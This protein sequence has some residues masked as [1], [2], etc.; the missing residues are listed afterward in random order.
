MDRASGNR[1][2]SLPLAEVCGEA[3]RLSERHG[4]LLSGV[5]ST[6]FHALCAGDE[7]ADDLV[8]ALPEKERLELRTW[9]QP[10]T[11]QP[12]PFADHELW[13]DSAKHEVELHLDRD[14]QYTEDPLEIWSTGHADAVWESIDLIPPGAEVDEWGEEE[15]LR[16]VP[17]GDLKRS[18]WT[19]H[20][21]SLQL[22]AYGLAAAKRAKADGYVCGIFVLKTGEWRWG[23]PVLL[24]SIEAA[25][26]ERRLKNA[27]ANDGP[28]VRGSHCD[29]CFNR[30]RCGEYLAP[31]TAMLADG[32]PSWTDEDLIAICT[33]DGITDENAVRILELSQAAKELHTLIDDALRY[34]AR[35]NPI[36]SGGKVWGPGKPGT[37]KR[38]DTESLTRD[39]PE[40]VEKY[41]KSYPRRG[42]YRWRK[43]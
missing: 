21:D 15:T 32:D 22:H 37:V 33:P 13:Y 8:A 12:L 14:M 19:S 27:I 26:I 7:N 34:Y 24:A 1:M 36:A 31:A 17:V 18:P 40:L 28:P 29:D 10:T 16:I 39:H 6:A 25:S 23:T 42:A 9:H 35:T 41:V 30:P 4:S 2:S 11:T 5:Q 3:P 20:V 38:I 43:A